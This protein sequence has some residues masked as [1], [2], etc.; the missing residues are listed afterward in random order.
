MKPRPHQRQ[1]GFVLDGS[2]SSCRARPLIPGSVIGGISVIL[3]VV[4]SGRRS[5]VSKLFS[6]A[7]SIH[8]I[9]YQF[10]SFT[11]LGLPIGGTMRHPVARRGSSSEGGAA[12]T[13]G[14]EDLRPRMATRIGSGNYWRSSHEYCLICVRADQDDRFDYHGLPPVASSRVA[15]IPRSPT[16][17]AGSSR[18][19]APRRG[20][21]C[22]RAKRSKAGVREGTERRRSNIRHKGCTIVDG[23]PLTISEIGIDGLHQTMVV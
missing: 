17:C 22:S 16:P 1:C 20:S 10:R 8:H 3:A 21:N 2:G 18:S 4:G 9:G 14:P 12:A 6:M 15:G 19:S 23:T 7:D 11:L 5:S 13:G